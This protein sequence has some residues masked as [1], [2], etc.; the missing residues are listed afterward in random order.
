M[1]PGLADKLLSGGTA[2]AGLLLVFLGAVATGFDAYPAPAGRTVVSKYRRRAVTAAV[3]F[4]FSMLAAFVGLL[5][6]WLPRA[7]QIVGLA[8]LLVSFGVAAWLA[9]LTIQD[10]K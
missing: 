6:N 8:S 4:A 2:L 10:I 7:L 5:S 1:I 9:Y 3:G